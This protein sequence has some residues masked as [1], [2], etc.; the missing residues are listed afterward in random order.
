MTPPLAES[1]EQKKGFPSSSSKSFSKPQCVS[2]FGDLAQQANPSIEV[3]PNKADFL[4]PH[5]HDQPLYKR[6]NYLHLTLLGLTPIL[7]IYGVLTCEYHWQTL[8]WAVGYYLFSGL[9]ITAGKLLS[10]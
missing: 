7:A 1:S 3:D 2:R 4:G 5:L 6:I 8:A 9:G 10:S